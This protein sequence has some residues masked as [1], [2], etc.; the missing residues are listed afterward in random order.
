VFGLAGHGED[1][2]EAGSDVF[3]GDVGAELAGRAAGGEPRDLVA[4]DRVNERR[5]VGE[6]PVERADADPGFACGAGGG[7]ACSPSSSP[8]PRARE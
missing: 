6:V 1:A 2:D 5:A 3:G 7:S 4:V 8:G